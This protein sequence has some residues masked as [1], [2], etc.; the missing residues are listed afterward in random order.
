LHAAGDLNNDGKGDILGIDAKGDLWRYLGRG[1]GTFPS[2]AKAGNGWGTYE[3]SAGA[4]LSGD[5]LA[6]IVGL[7][8]KTRILYYYKGLG[9]GGFHTKKQIATGW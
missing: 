1:D 7:D 8:T 4:D 2:K 6:D 9:G 3:L 5:K